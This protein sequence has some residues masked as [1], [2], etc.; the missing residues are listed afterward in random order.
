MLHFVG[1]CILS[2]A[3]NANEFWKSRTVA[4]QFARLFVPTVVTQ[5]ARIWNGRFQFQMYAPRPRS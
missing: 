1:G 5:S 2:E 4:T 3:A